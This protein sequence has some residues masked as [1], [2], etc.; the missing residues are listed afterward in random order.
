MRFVIEAPQTGPGGEHTGPIIDHVDSWDVVDCETCGFAHI[1][2]V[3]SVDDLVEIYR[4]D[5]YTTEKPLYLNHHA[6]DLEWW[7]LVYGERLKELEAL[8]PE[9]GRRMLD[10]GSGPGYFLQTAIGR[11]WKVQGVEP[12]THAAEHARGLGIPVVNGFFD[13]DMAK[14]LG[15]FDV[16]H[17]SEVLEHIPDPHALVDA[18]IS[19]M[20]PGGLLY[21]MVPNE[22]NP[23]QA[24]LRDHCG[25][26][27][28]WVSPPHHINYFTASS[29]ECLLEAH[30]LDVVFR[31]ATFPIDMFLLMGQNYVGN[32]ELGRQCH[33]LRK[34]FEMNLLESGR[35][36]LMR[37]LYR[38][39]AQLGLGRLV[40]AAGRKMAD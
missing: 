9:G 1:V 38:S 32:D 2:P 7:R 30:G 27:P 35:G 21:A 26:E 34:T 10:V 18:T 12:S 13:A 6:E 16:V 19:A 3:P 40:A 8:L 4:D 15:E 31:E 25:F 33:G 23:V 24:V 28:W 36:D 14:E 39:F 11:G 37:D 5:Y 20:R 29:L 22:Y 17:M